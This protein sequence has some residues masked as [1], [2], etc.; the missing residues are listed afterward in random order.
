[1]YTEQE[2][3]DSF[4]AKFVDGREPGITIGLE[5]EYPVVYGVQGKPSF[6]HSLVVEDT[7]RLFSA[8]VESDKSWTF[9]PDGYGI[10]KR[11]GGANGSWN[12]E[13]G[14][15]FGSGTLEMGLPPVAS[16]QEAREALTSH[17]KPAL[18]VAGQLGLL[19]LGSGTNPISEPVRELAVKK[20]RYNALIRFAGNGVF[21]QSIIAA[22]QTHLSFSSKLAIQGVN[23]YNGFAPA[24][25]AIAANGA[26]TLGKPNGWH[27]FRAAVWDGLLSES[28][29]YVRN[30]HRVG[31]AVRY[32]DWDHYWETLKS[33]T[34]IMSKRRDEATG[35]EYY[36][37][38]NNVRTFAEFMR[39]GKAQA[40][41]LNGTRKGE[42][43]TVSPEPKDVEFLAGTVWH[44]ARLSYY[45]TI[46]TRAASQQPDSESKI[47]IA[48]LQLGLAANIDDGLMVV[49]RF[50]P[51]ALRAARR[52]AAFRGL[53]AEVTDNRGRT[54]PMSR[55]V[56]QMLDISELGLRSRGEDSS[57]LDP[58]RERLATG[59]TPAVIARETWMA[60]ERD[61]KNGAHAHIL[62]TKLKV[63]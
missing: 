36:I 63:A 17:L 13:F 1:M 56:G 59:R 14:L 35:E 57:A 40:T 41:I 53:D 30:A 23:M 42:V 10:T 49:E 34:P 43:I 6:G 62:R 12:M 58:L 3:K 5:S 20:E 54:V 27:D 29:Q 8:V 61:G 21:Q 15:D 18:V 48:A 38:F 4:M 32:R 45:G 39:R 28:A 47:A 24:L 52:D 55:L 50:T 37:Q 26:I 60:A 44:D 11:V 19:V 16:I 2:L 25:I 46:E 9:L 22:E 33:F 7:L 31:I 51:R